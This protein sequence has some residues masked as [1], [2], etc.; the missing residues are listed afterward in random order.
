M[1][2]PK[3]ILI[4]F[5]DIGMGKTE[6]WMDTVRK[7]PGIKWLVRGNHDN[8]SCQWYVENELF[9]MA[10]DGLIYRGMWITHKP[11]L[12]ELPAGTQLNLHGHLHNVWDGFYPEDPEKDQE[13]FVTCARAGTLMYPWQR[14]L[15]I[16]YTGY[17]PVD[18]DKFVSRGH[19][20]WQSTGP[21]AE[22]K[23]RAALKYADGL[24]CSACIP[25]STGDST[26]V[27]I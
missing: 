14:L 12:T 24:K 5:G 11:W 25:D 23:K 18:Y 27:V 16:E 13:E 8:K 21:N 2:G 1:V 3:D 20:L 7:W 17:M 6:D 4:H 10:C 9:H 19:K 26:D 15:A 22:T